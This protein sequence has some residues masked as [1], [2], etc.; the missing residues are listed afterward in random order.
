MKSTP[1]NIFLTGYLFFCSL[2]FS[3][4]VSAQIAVDGTTSTEVTNDNSDFTINGGNRAGGNLFHS[5]REFSVPTG[6]SANFNNAPDVNNINTNR[7]N[8]RIHCILHP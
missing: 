7:Y 3:I 2:L 1:P 6:G 8:H 4:P 5:F